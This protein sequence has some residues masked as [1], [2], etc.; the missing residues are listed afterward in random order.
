MTAPLV[1]A[2]FVLATA[3][4]APRHL[5]VARWVQ[6]APTL[7]IVVWQA[8]TLTV[9][10]STLLIGLTLALPIL[11]VGPQL[12]SV[13]GTGHLD[14]TDHYA[15]PAGNGLAVL[16]LVGVVA[17]ALRST[18][19]LMTALR[20]ASRQRRMQ[21]AGLQLVG[22]PHPAG[23]TVID[24]DVPLVYCLPGRQRAVVVTRGA[25]D[26]LTPD[27]LESVLAHERTHLRARHDLALALSAALARTAGRVSLFR[28]AHEQITTL[29]E[30]QAD[31][32]A[33]G[34]DARRAMATALM[35][36]GS[37]SRPADAGAASTESAAPRIRRLINAA[38]LTGARQR[39]AVALGAVAL[40]AAPVGLALSPALEASTNDCCHVAEDG[41]LV[42]R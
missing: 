20:R 21:L 13:M 27:E 19:F 5:L 4:A 36:L 2:L 35:T 33:R 10:L 25:L 12:T 31:D 1:L 41:Q 40:L 6:R 23:F 18:Y 15:T 17:L 30:M 29:I 37:T 32:A 28:T 14:V 39:C 26:A 38:P 8:V 42:R 24:H 3:W 16:A 7:G 22:A 9:L 34:R 11:P